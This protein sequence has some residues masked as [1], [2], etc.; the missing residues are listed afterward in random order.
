MSSFGTFLAGVVLLIVGLA[1]G[2][3]LLDVPA[4]WIGVSALVLLGAGVVTA[5]LRTKPRDRP[6]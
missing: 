6:T 4:T 2:A 5:T 1:V 3:H